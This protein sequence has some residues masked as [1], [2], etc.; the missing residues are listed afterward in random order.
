MK[1]VHVINTCTILVLLLVSVSTAAQQRISV[2]ERSYKG[3]RRVLD[4]GIQ[5]LGGT[6][7]FGHVEDISIKYNMKAFEVGQSANPEAPYKVRR[8]EG[9]RVIDL[10]GKRSYRELKTNYHVCL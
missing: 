5:A 8:E 10:R 6:E 9:V 1:R 3:A 4:K 7:T 2:S